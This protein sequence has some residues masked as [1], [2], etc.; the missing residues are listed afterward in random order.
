MNAAELKTV[1]RNYCIKNALPENKDKYR[2]Y[3]KDGLYDGFGLAAPQI[4]AAVKELLASGNLMIN[5][6]METATYMIMN[7]KS[8]EIAISMLLCSALNK[9]YQREHFLMM[10]NW[11]SAGITNW[12]HADT[13]GM[14]VLP[15][16]LS[17]KIITH[18]D[19][20]PW[21]S[22]TNKFQRRS[23]PVTLIK[24]LKTFHDYNELFNLVECLMLDKEREVHQGM[25]WFLREAWKKKPEVTE[26]FLFKWKDKSPRLIIQYATEKMQQEEKLK[27]RKGKP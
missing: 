23:V 19:L 15:P 17:L 4:H 9:Q 2:R 10:Q 5:E 25:G 11:Y 22:A 12:A 7:G 16:F 26:Q 1:I 8:E 24:S 14:A 20:I 6:V 3:F 27:F 18:G 21:L 13:M